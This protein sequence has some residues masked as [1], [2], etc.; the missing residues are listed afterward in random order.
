MP[1]DD[2]VWISGGIR[3]RN[4]KRGVPRYQ[5][6][7][8]VPDPDRDRHRYQVV[9]TFG[10][11]VDAVQWL[12]REKVR[13]RS[14]PPRSRKSGRAP[15]REFFQYWIEEV[16]VHR[17]RP[18]TVRS[19]R[20]MLEHAIREIGDIPLYRLS[21]FDVQAFYTRLK[22]AGKSP[23]TIR[24]AGQVLR[25]VLADAVR[26]QIIRDN[27]ATVAKPPR[28]QT[29]PARSLTWD[30]VRQLL[31]AADHDPLRVLWYLYLL[32]GM[33]RGEALGLQWRD[34]DWEHST[35]AV[36]RTVHMDNGVSFPKTESSARLV[37]LPADLLDM[38]RN[39]QS[40]QAARYLGDRVVPPR[41]GWVFSSRTGHVQSPRN[42]S[43][44]FKLLV[45]QAGLDPALH[46]H[47]LRHTHA[48][49]LLAQGV[50]IKVVSERLGH[51]DIAMTLQ[52]YGH[53]LPGMQQEAVE[54]FVD[55]LKAHDEREAR[56][57]R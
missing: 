28:E 16:L 15:S 11:R 6:Y 55:R 42:V 8:N 53:V 39:Y 47:E 4:T 22:K 9:K 27:P 56:K 38:L 10:R 31:Q 3:V 35:I 30:E 26:W 19:Y 37:H 44:A 20:Q 34:V 7:I 48:S 18:A 33:R 23:R 50:P 40:D 57:N 45:V 17:V 14:Q 32:T 29:R 41:D 25:R 54:A 51:R 46:I 13:I 36:V 43:R 5:A 2:E 12:D 52:V 24:Y 49:L 1:V 21:A